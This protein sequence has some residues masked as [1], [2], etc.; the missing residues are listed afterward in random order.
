M[1][2]RGC[3]AGSL[4]GAQ[5]A[6]EAC[7]EEAAPGRGWS[8]PARPG[9]SPR[10]RQWG[11]PA[12]GHSGRSTP[13][14]SRR[15]SP[16]MPPK[17]RLGDH[18]PRPRTGVAPQSV[19][20]CG[21]GPR[22]LEIKGSTPGPQPPPVGGGGVPGPEC[23]SPPAPSSGQPRAHRNAD[24][25]ALRAPAALASPPGQDSRLTRA[26]PDTHSPGARALLP[27][28]RTH[29][30]ASSSPPRPGWGA[31]RVPRPQRATQTRGPCA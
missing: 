9:P 23:R 26:Q 19:G 7:P 17:S 21:K 6:E 8:Q 31:S 15:P 5:L 30:R 25:E 11:T 13:P 10:V 20:G 22:R 24:G 1:R 4:A 28:V 29:G 18:P 3:R 2:P 14:P 27:A 12:R 16:G